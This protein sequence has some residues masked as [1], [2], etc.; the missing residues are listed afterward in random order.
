VVEARD[1]RGLVA[2]SDPSVGGRHR[3]A[4][5]N[6]LD[7]DGQVADG[8]AA[9]VAERRRAQ[10]RGRVVAFIAQ[11][12]RGS[13]DRDRGDDAAVNTLE[14]SP[15]VVDVRP[16]ATITESRDGG[17]VRPFHVRRAG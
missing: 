17:G 9:D 7:V 1:S 8:I 13:V 16:E 12:G 14:G 3:A 6:D 15:L 10:V 4:P 2:L 5:S 11:H